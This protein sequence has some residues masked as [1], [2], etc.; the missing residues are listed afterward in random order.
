[1]RLILYAYIFYQVQSLNSVD[2]LKSRLVFFDGIVSQYGESSADSF[3]QTMFDFSAANFNLMILESYSSVEYTGVNGETTNVKNTNGKNTNVENT[4]GHLQ[5]ALA[6]WDR[7]GDN[8]RN[9]VKTAVSSKS[10][11][12]GFIG[13]TC[14][15]Y[16]DQVSK[17]T[18]FKN[19][20]SDCSTYA[21]SVAL[22]FANIRLNFGSLAGG[23]NIDLVKSIL[24]DMVS[25]LTL[26]IYVTFDEQVL[27]TNND[28][29][30]YKV[31]LNWILAN[32]KNDNIKGIIIRYNEEILSQ[33]KFDNI[34][35][36][37]TSQTAYSQSL[38]NLTTILGLESVDKILPV[39]V[40]TQ[41]EPENTAGGIVYGFIPWPELVETSL[42]IAQMKSTN[43]SGIG[44]WS[45][46][47]ENGGA[48]P[49]I[50]DNAKEVIGIGNEFRSIKAEF[51]PCE[52]DN[53]GECLYNPAICDFCV[54]YY[55]LENGVCNYDPIE[56]TTFD[57]SVTGNMTT[58]NMTTND[59]VTESSSLNIKSLTNS[60]SAVVFSIFLLK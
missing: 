36:S 53:C 58:S 18:D 50:N 40:A 30:L 16:K 25:V 17:N 8:Y 21:K 11:D 55:V 14:G 48:D 42:K 44:V 6:E 13:F 41:N 43:L 4:N 52:I 3:R 60:V 45:Y 1:M 57:D 33:S 26:P 31:C 10:K 22:D 9:Q 56:T 59:V 38:Q 32:I 20:A 5:G 39:K 24:D 15:D 37:W 2:L 51:F 49:A 54:N 23:N 19:L 34:Y 47:T 7:M 29:S 35:G 27:D 28:V 46:H 12:P